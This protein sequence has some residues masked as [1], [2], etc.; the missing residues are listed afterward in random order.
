VYE[1][2]LRRVQLELAR[3]GL[4]SGEADGRFD[5][6]TREALESLQANH[7]L[8]A[9]GLPDERTLQVLFAGSG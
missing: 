5:P 1:E 7:E 4:R 6:A 3:R 2:T 9:M 8:P